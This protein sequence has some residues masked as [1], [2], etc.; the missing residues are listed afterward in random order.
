[1]L[2]T[3]C[4]HC[5]SRSSLRGPAPDPGPVVH[6]TPHNPRDDPT[7]QAPTTANSGGSEARSKFDELYQKVLEETEGALS[8]SLGAASLGGV[9]VGGGS[10]GAR[11][12]PAGVSQTVN[13]TGQ[14]YNI[15]LFSTF[16]Y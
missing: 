3:L 14:Y 16:C 2:L 12:E 8:T 5:Q 13:G 7:M 9:S 11:G 1:M 6:H 10:L 15:T 4:Y